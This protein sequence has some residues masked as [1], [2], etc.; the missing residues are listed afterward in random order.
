M[1]AE[2][3]A[4]VKSSEGVLSAK[5]HVAANWLIV[6]VCP[7]TVMLPLRALP[8]VLAVR[9]NAIFEES[10]P[11]VSDVKVINPALDVA[12]QAHPGP[13][14]TSKLPELPAGE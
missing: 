6:K 8:P 14:C 11:E 9:L 13:V 1:V 5:E 12:V 2:P 3:P 7:L 4:A 10:V